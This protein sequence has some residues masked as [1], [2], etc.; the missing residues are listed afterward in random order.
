M[1]FSLDGD[2][3][4][5]FPNTE[6]SETTQ[7]KLYCDAKMSWLSVDFLLPLDKSSC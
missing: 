6:P 3:M 1:L 7:V 5:E 2:W 4:K